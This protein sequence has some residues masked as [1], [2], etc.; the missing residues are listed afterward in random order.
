MYIK[1]NFNPKLWQ[2]YELKA[3]GFLLP[4]SSG[5]KNGVVLIDTLPPC[6]SDYDKFF[7]TTYAVAGHEASHLI[8]NLQIAKYVLEGFVWGFSP[9]A[10]AYIHYELNATF[11]SKVFEIHA[12]LYSAWKLGTTSYLKERFINLKPWRASGGVNDTHPSDK[13]R[14][15]YLH[16]FGLF[17]K[18]DATKFRNSETYQRVMKERNEF[19]SRHQPK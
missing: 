9:L 11:Y 3:R 17:I 13:N 18:K 7:K 12:D 8:F 5:K 15:A 19:N 10:G 14:I 2:P 1:Y 4:D 16:Y 6:K